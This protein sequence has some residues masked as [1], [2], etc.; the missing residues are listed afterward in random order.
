MNARPSSTMWISITGTGTGN[1]TLLNMAAGTTANITPASLTV[2]AIGV[3]KI[4]DGGTSARVTLSDNRI[5]NVGDTFTD[6]YAGANFVTASAGTGIA[7]NVAGI[8]ISGAG[9]RNY[10]MLN[11]IAITTANISPALLT[12][13]A[14]GVDKVYDGTTT[15]TEPSP[16]IAS[17]TWVIHSLTITPRTLR[18]PMWERILWSA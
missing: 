12:A 11:A 17:R 1:Y 6:S 13:T 10:T 5:Q 2:G 3:D 15:A 9:V 8:S 7:V 18:P 14:I 16:T 4:Y